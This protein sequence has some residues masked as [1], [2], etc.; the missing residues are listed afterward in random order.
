MFS[1]YPLLTFL[2]IVVFIFTE[3]QY[4]ILVSSGKE[5]VILRVGH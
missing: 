4:S 3:L 1:A 5:H 2:G